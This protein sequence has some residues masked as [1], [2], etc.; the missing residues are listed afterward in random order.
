MHAVPPWAKKKYIEIWYEMARLEGVRTGRAV[1]VDHIVPLTS[2]IVCGLHCEDN[3]QLLFAE[4]NV[5][6]S[7]KFWP[8]MP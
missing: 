3:M 1:H 2:K 6:K 8:D 4:D 7:N 5:A